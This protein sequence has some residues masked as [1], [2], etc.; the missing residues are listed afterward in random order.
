[1]GG[2]CGW[3]GGGVGVCENEGGREGKAERHERPQKEND[4]GT[5]SLWW[6]S[7]CLLG[8]CWRCKR[9]TFEARHAWLDVCGCVGVKCTVHWSVSNGHMKKKKEEEEEDGERRRGAEGRAGR[10]DE[11]KEEDDATPNDSCTPLL[12]SSFTRA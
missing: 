2:C 6:A 3:V 12:R 4:K 1:M 5:R 8:R 7:E 9:Q 11:E 10:K